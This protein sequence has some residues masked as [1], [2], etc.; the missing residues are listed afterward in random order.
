MIMCSIYDISEKLLEKFDVEKMI[1]IVCRLSGE[2]ISKM[3][4]G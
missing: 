4:C 2:E 3:I 1:E